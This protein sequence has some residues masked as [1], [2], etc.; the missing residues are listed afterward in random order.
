MTQF[1]PELGQM[2]WGQP[3]QEHETSEL[4]DAALTYLDHELQ[5][6]LWNRLQKECASPFSNSGARFKTDGLS[7]HA[8][9]W[10][11]ENQPWNLKCGDVEISW[12]KWSG[13]GQSVNR[14]MQSEDV[15]AFLDRALAIVRACDTPEFGDEDGG[16]PFTYE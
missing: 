9:D 15:A 5:R 7:I 12:Y 10:G 11:D 8:Y 2:V 3:S 6:V 4:L 1:Q 14:P 16:R 13:R